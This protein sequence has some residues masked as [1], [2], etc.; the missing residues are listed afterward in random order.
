MKRTSWGR[1]TSVVI[2]WSGELERRRDGAAI[3]RNHGPR[4]GGRETLATDTV[5][6]ESPTTGPHDGDVLDDSITAL[7]ARESLPHLRPRDTST[8]SDLK[9]DHDSLLV[10]SRQTRRLTLVLLSN[11]KKI[12]QQDKRKPPLFGAVACMCKKIF[13]ARTHKPPSQIKRTFCIM[14]GL[15]EKCC[16]ISSIDSNTISLFL[17]KKVWI[18]KQTD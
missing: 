2:G 9:L 5:A 17:S 16:F 10:V 18:N 6:V 11:F 4:D 14:V 3:E 12:T 7:R 13:Y 1:R 15:Y 8:D